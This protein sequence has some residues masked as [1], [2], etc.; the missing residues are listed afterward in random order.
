MNSSD[1]ASKKLKGRDVS[2]APL[3]NNYNQKGRSMIE[4]LGVLAIIG[5]LSVGGIAGYSKAMHRY[6]VNKTIEQTT[7]IAGNIRAFFGPQ[8][9]Y[10]DLECW[11]ND[12]GCYYNNCPIV[13]KAKIIPDEMLTIDD[14]GKITA[15]TNS[16][17]GKVKLQE[18][19][20]ICT[21]NSCYEGGLDDKAFHIGYEVP[22]IEAC[23]D[24]LTHD[25]HNANV[26]F[27]EVY[28]VN[29]GDNAALT[30]PIEVDNAI[31]VCSNAY[32]SDA[33][34]YINIWFFFDV[35]I[36]SYKDKYKDIKNWY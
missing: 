21:K 25:W 9:N 3:I 18:A 8:K 27:I 14:S 28:G 10:A 13:R 1:F 35:D 4:M 32:P 11:C 23:V 15:I 12:Y 31:D 33:S 29:K 16:F 5:V 17:G 24:L 19:D 2:A 7:L 22:S 26:D 36:D 34:Q 30:F 20:K 6:K